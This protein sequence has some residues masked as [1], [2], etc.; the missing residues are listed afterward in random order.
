MSPACPSPP[1]Q[2]LP[3]LVLPCL[4]RHL[5]TSLAQL[6]AP[7]AGQR[8]VAPGVHSAVTGLTYDQNCSYS[9][10]KFYL[11]GLYLQLFLLAFS[12][13]RDWIS[14]FCCKFT[15]KWVP[16][17]WWKREQEGKVNATGELSHHSPGGLKTC[18][19]AQRGFCPQELKPQER[20]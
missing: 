4:H 20:S 8:W 15:S 3:V 10:L 14:C 12:C 2:K 18:V 9:H 1:R 13:P 7:R 19:S 16:L 6:S 17:L 11:P 5:P